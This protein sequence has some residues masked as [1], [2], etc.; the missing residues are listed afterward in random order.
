[1][2]EFAKLCKEYEGLSGAERGVML[3][4]NAVKILAK[5]KLLDLPGIDPVDTLA[6]FILG[7]VVADE[8]VNE[9]EYLLIYP[10]LVRVFGDD[11]DFESIKEG[12]R[13]DRDG[14]NMVKKYT[15]E[16]LS[17]LAVAD[18]GLCEDVI[19][20]CLCVV[21]VDGKISLKERNYIRKLCRA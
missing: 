14:Q 2:F 20:L 8:R 4:A 13:K 12:F 19:S 1:M 21:T 9:Q 16:M 18:E 15:Q 5:L 3:T 10:A 7:S 11:F 17:V 6:G